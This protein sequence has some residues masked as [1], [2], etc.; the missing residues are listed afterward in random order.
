MLPQS[1]NQKTHSCQGRAFKTSRH[2]RRTLFHFWTP[3]KLRKPTKRW[4]RKRSRQLS[5]NLLKLSSLRSRATI[6][7][8]LRRGLLM[9]LHRRRFT[10]S[11][12]RRK[13][14]RLQSTQNPKLR[15]LNSSGAPSEREAIPK[16][17]RS[18]CA[19]THPLLRIYRAMLKNRSSTETIWSQSWRKMVRSLRAA[20][21]QENHQTSRL[22]KRCPV[23]PLSKPFQDEVEE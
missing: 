22:Q 13:R 1:W 21:P 16:T 7:A 17:R 14:S 18:L 20:F 6:I 8:R 10:L 19:R 15:L 2:P 3:I 23:A 9:N 11:L 5:S 12:W 4:W